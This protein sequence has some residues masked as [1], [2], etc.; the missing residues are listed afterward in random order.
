MMYTVPLTIN[1]LTMNM[2]RTLCWVLSVYGNIYFLTMNMFRTLCWVWSVYGNIYFLTMNM[3]RT[4]CWVWSVY[5]NGCTSHAE[6]TNHYLQS[7]GE[8]FIYF[9]IIL[10]KL[11]RSARPWLLAAYSGIV[12]V[13]RFGQ[14]G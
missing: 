3:F 13:E 10:K 2:F 4:L 1:F 14:R 12:W 8:F 6:M 11:F 9:F 7:F 5:G